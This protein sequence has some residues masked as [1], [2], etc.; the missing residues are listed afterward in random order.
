MHVLPSA[1]SDADALVDMCLHECI[2]LR[3]Q[4]HPSLSLEFLSLIN[5]QGLRSPWLLD[6]QARALVELGQPRAAHSLWSRLLQH[7]DLAAAETAQAMTASLEDALL[8]ALQELLLRDGWSTRFLHEQ[9]GDPV[10]VRLLNEVIAAREAGSP[11]LSHDLAATALQLGWDDPWL[12]DN[13]ARALVELGM[14]SDAISIWKQLEN[15]SDEDVALSAHEMV[16]LYGSRVEEQELQECCQRLIEQG[17]R[18]EAQ[19]LLLRA[20]SKTPSSS[21]LREQLGELVSEDRPHDL[22]SQELQPR[23][24]ALTI[25]ER[26]LDIL[27]EQLNGRPS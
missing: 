4:G 5:E 1:V 16:K 21:G 12:L 15:S 25:H 7:S 18:Q 17:D 9:D 22:L 13:Q 24:T 2:E 27:E 3:S 14:E 8:N 20:L 26:L 11:Q 6:N 10:L 23:A 19:T